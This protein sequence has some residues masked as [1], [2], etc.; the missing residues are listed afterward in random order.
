MKILRDFEPFPGRARGPAQHCGPGQH[1]PFN[2]A[3]AVLGPGRQPVGWARHG[4]WLKHAR[5]WPIR[6]PGPHR[7]GT[8]RISGLAHGWWNLK[9]SVANKEAQLFSHGSLENFPTKN[10]GH[11]NKWWITSSSFC[12]L[13]VISFHI[14][15]FLQIFSKNYIDKLYRNFYDEE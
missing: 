5:P 6:R 14:F 15:L 9:F 12:F 4:P 13:K 7:A 2:K 8:A 1:D 3:C 11:S 10:A